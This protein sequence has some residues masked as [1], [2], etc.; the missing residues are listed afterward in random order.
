M[1]EANRRDQNQASMGQG[2]RAKRP[3]GAEDVLVEHEESHE[4]LVPPPPP[5][6]KHTHA[7]TGR[8]SHTQHSSTLKTMKNKGLKGRFVPPTPLGLISLMRG[9]G[10]QRRPV[11]FES[12]GSEIV[13][14][15]I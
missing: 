13:D 1:C 7:H 5:P 9:V 12:M 2:A 11:D 6:P 10:Y 3:R 4:P 8:H 14:S 15:V